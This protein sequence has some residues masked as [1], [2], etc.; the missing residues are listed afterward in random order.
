MSS[1]KNSVQARLKNLSQ[2]LNVSV[3]VLLASYFF[4]VFLFRLSKSEYSENF[5]F[6]GG[7]YLSAIIGI[8][9]RYTQD[10]D[11]KLSD[12]NLDEENIRKIINEIAGIPSDDGIYFE[13]T[14]VSPIRNEDEYGG[15]SV[16]LTGHL[17]NIRQVV[18]IDIATGD[19][20]TPSAVTYKY[21]RFL[22]NDFLD[23]KAYNLETI[24]AEKLQT[25]FYRG[26]LNTRS[27]DFY[28]IFI[29]R[30]LKMNE[31]NKENLK[32][33]FE[34][35]CA[36]RNTHFSKNEAFGLLEKISFSEQ[37]SLQ[38]KNYTKKNSFAADISFSD[39]VDACRDMTELVF[40]RFF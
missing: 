13:L 20:V 40:Q 34:K 11:F 26:L 24:I 27:K 28:D 39:V 6:K 25:V 1:S 38:W 8:Q 35:T 17:E 14:S 30:K 36:Y 3:N 21:K 33:A 9:N 19:P 10:L 7:F 37:M 15:F 29:I 12:Q 18:N 31:I 22:E 4:D 23:F 16:S 32:L 2:K 5:I